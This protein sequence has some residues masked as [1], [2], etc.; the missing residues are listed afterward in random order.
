[1][2]SKWSG[3]DPLAGISDDSDDEEGE[4]AVGNEASRNFSSNNG[5]GDNKTS[6]SGQFSAPQVLFRFPSFLH[7]CY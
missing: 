2:A 7:Y 4:E 1:M 5:E 6:A 3:M